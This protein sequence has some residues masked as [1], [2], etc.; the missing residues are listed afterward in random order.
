MDNPIMLTPH[1]IVTIIL[2]VCGAIITV[3]AAVTIIVNF[4]KK[5][6]EPEN[7]QNSRITSLETRALRSRQGC[8]LNA[9]SLWSSVTGCYV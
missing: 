6:K 3:S 9:L 8:F 7:M 4:I 2:A 5:A 1:D